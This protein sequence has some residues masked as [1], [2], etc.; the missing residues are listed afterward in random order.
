MELV[1]GGG[2]TSIGQNII[3]IGGIEGGLALDT[4]YSSFLQNTH[5]HRLTRAKNVCLM[6]VIFYIRT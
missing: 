5:Y 2:G 4:S 6:L 3:L 1:S